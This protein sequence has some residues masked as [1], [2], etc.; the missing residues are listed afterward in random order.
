MLGI[1]DDVTIN[2]VIIFQVR[3]QVPNETR[4]PA[5]RYLG[6]VL[7]VSWEAIRGSPG[8]CRLFRR[9]GLY[10]GHKVGGAHTR[11]ASVA[12]SVSS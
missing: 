6:P 2:N 4:R 11:G 7:A 5:P 8:V 3:F 9:P 1:G 10:P 12:Y